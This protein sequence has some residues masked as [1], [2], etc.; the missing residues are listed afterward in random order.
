MP[1]IRANGIEIYYELHGPEGAEV[2]VLSNGVLMNTA[3]WVHQVPVLS[4][5]YRLLLYDCRGMWQSDHPPGPYSMELHA[6]DL[7]ALLEALGIARA[8]IGGISY[9]AEISMAFGLKYPEKTRSLIL[10]SAVSQVEPQLRSFIEGWAAAA[11]ARDPELLY[12]VV[13]P[14]SFSEAWLG[15]NRRLL[16]AS[17]QRYKLLDFEAFLE[18][19]DSFL[20]LNLTGELQKI[21]APALVLVGE[22]DILKPRRYSELIAR[23]IPNAE[24]FVVP[25]AGH[26]LCWEAPDAFNTLVLGFLAKQR[27]LKKE[28]V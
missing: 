16:E 28:A 19:L 27:G 6:D 9:G 20:R 25:N 12:R 23:A 26:A 14:L 24:F 4:R 1:K 2:L 17:R 3:G 15:A 8:H 11:R 21:A 22:Q 10:S 7:A 18:L 5:H 13:S